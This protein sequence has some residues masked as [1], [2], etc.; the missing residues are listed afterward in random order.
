MTTAPLIV[1][2]ALLTG[3]LLRGLR[4]MPAFLVIGLV[5]PVIWLL[6]F[7]QLFR[8]VVDLPGFAHG[9]FLQFLTPGVVMMT[10]LF[11]SAWAGTT[12]LQDIDRGVMDRMLTSPVHRGALVIASLAYQ[13]VQTLVQ[14]LV[15]MAVALAAGARFSG[16]AAGVGVTVLAA[17]LLT[18]IFSAVSGAVALLT[19]QQATLIAISQF[20][21][22]PLMFLSSAVMDLGLAPAWVGRVADYNP[23]EWAVAAAREAMLAHPDW[24]TVSARLGLLAA[25]AVATGLL[26]T[27]AFHTYRNSA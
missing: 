26:S 3:R 15:I 20:T 13:A 4:R 24:S 14:S 18:V 10:A 22:L 17:V 21:T 16:G 23:V 27:R 12:H 7:G 2:S 25:A 19:R 8:S 11:A 5:Q 9:G 6:L 1:H